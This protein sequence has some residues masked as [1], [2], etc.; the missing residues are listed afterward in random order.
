MDSKKILKE[1][2]ENINIVIAHDTPLGKSLWQALLEIH[3]AD[4]ADFLTDNT[5]KD[6]QDLFMAMPK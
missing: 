4:I 1:I 2:Q 6:A 5:K 3:P